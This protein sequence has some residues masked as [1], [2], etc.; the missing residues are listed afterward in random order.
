MSFTLDNPQWVED[1]LF[2]QIVAGSIPAKKVLETETALVF[3]DITP[4]APIHWL[5]IAKTH[6]ASHL[7]TTDEAVYATLLSI[8]REAAIQQGLTDYR[9]VINN[10]AGAGQSVFH[11]HLHLLAGRPF[12]WPPG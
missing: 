8:A 12:S 7:E 1:C 6:T 9:L 11:M 3:E 2:C 4:Q 5:I 10:G